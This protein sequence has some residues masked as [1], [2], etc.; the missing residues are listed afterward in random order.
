MSKSRLDDM[1]V[2]F[3]KKTGQPN[4]FEIEY[5]ASVSQEGLDPV[6]E[7]TIVCELTLLFPK[8]KCLVCL[9]SLLPV[10]M[11]SALI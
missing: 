11:S 10:Y 6:E 8:G 9:C 3:L 1:A 7:I 4:G 5:S 2:F